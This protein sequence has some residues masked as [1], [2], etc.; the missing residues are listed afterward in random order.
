MFVY[1]R[2]IGLEKGDIQSLEVSSPSHDRI[3]ETA[4]E[5]LD[6]NKAQLFVSIGIN[7]SGRKL[8]VGEYRALYVVKRDGA[9]I[10]RREISAELAD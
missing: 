6:A 3:A 2:A 7:R 8:P 9:G 1:F 4:F 10:L 5:P